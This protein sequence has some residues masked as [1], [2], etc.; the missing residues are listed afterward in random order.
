MLLRV[1]VSLVPHC[2][3]SVE[4]HALYTL[5]APEAALPMEFS[6]LFAPN[7]ED[8]DSG[9]EEW[10]DEL[11]TGEWS[12]VEWEWEWPDELTNDQ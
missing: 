7:D 5:Q 9:L 12:G 11:M 2:Y 3:A 6:T 8:S 1:R 10:P 4:L